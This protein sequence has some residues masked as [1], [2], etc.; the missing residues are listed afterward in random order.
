MIGEGLG[1]G[2]GICGIAA[3]AEQQGGI[4]LHQQGIDD[5]DGVAPKL[6][7]EVLRDGAGIGGVAALLG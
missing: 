7:E 1:Y 5:D 6:I 4:G 2:A 3:F